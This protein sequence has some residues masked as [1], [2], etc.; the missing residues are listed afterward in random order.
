MPKATLS[1]Q[2]VSTA[3][4]LSGKK[5]DYYDTAIKGFVLEVRQTGGSTYYMRYRDLRGRQC[6]FKIGDAKALTFDKARSTAKVIRA[7]V[8]LG[9]SPLQERQSLKQV[10]TLAQFNEERYLPYIKGYKKSWIGDEGNFR[11]HIL[12][13]FGSKHLDEI[14]HQQVVEFHQQMLASGLAKATCNRLLILLRYMFNLA[15]KWGIPG[16]QENPTLGV[17]LYEANNARERFLTAEETQRLRLAIEQS[18]N[19]Q[20][21]FI[22]PLLLLTGARKREL[23]DAKW[24]DFDTAR[25]NW[26]IPMSKSGKARHVPL[27]GAVL[28]IL[29]SLPRWPKCPY[30][31]P[32]PETLEPFVNVHYSW[33]TARVKAQ[34]PE[35]RMHDLR[36]S[37]ASNL[38]NS[39][40]SIYEV[41]KILG[42][43]QL[44]T[45]ERYA[46]LAHETL[47]AAADAASNDW[48]RGA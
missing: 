25:R 11:N 34:L 32:N 17:P 5:T 24:E 41:S 18:A 23:L 3:T 42:H 30:V 6:Q 7:K 9:E 14:T 38:V 1:A 22:I 20:L 36:H 33:N 13:R 4:C 40:R 10:P 2:F 19:P 26:R 37:M 35:V 39:G 45:S 12:P 47:L 15:K 44:K 28:E 31:V 48:R 16:A 43:S 21:K 27:S 8:T 46:H 29:S